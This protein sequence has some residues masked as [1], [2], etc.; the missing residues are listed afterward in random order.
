MTTDDMLFRS[1]EGRPLLLAVTDDIAPAIQRWR[2][3]GLTVRRL[4]GRKMRTAR[5]LFD[6]AAAALQF[7]DYFGENFDA[8]AECLGDL[9]EWIDPGKGYV[10]LVTDADEF[11]R[12]D[13]SSRAAF[14]EVVGSVQRSLSRPIASG[15][16]WDWPAVPFHVVLACRTDREKSLP[17][18]WSADIYLDR[19]VR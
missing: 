6:E 11:L 15:E 14:E 9:P 18:A 16:W 13:R 3:R 19:L 8:L 1:E 12:R 10:V 2:E 4:R 5:G 7:P 17:S